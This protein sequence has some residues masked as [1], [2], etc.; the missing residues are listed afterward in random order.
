MFIRV[1]L[2]IVSLLL[3]LFLAL[4]IF[5][6]FFGDLTLSPLASVFNSGRN[7]VDWK[8]LPP[9]W[10]SPYFPGEGPWLYDSGEI[11]IFPKE[12]RSTKSGRLQIR[13]SKEY[14][15]RLIYDVTYNFDDKGRRVVIDADNFAAQSVILAGCSFVFGTGLEDEETLASQLQRE[16][17]ILPNW[18]I[19][20]LGLGGA[21]VSSFLSKRYLEM[22][23][24]P[25]SFLEPLE[26]QEVVFIWLL[27]DFHFFRFYCHPRCFLPEQAF[28]AGAPEVQLDGNEARILE[29]TF[30][31]S[32]DGLVLGYKLLADLFPSFVRKIPDFRY[33]ER[34]VDAFFSS[35]DLLV[36]RLVRPSAR[37][38]KVIAFH[39]P[40]RQTTLAK[41]QKVAEYHGYRVWDLTML[42]RVVPADYTAIPFDRHSTA[43]FN[44]YVAK[45][46]AKGIES[47]E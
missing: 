39:A 18:K 14:R 40:M 19:I 2:Y 9:I 28:F 43:L 35:L 42:R 12:T 23:G 24:K 34:D 45:L 7:V 38:R 21:T 16:I 5:S 8:S 36:R 29:N 47:L 32:K 25:E 31:E 33:G 26:Q 3:P 20:N 15:G 11:F 22:R 6:S 10:E 30:A 27:F 37:V 4:Q 46:L 41:V 13:E 44:W 17:R 1:T